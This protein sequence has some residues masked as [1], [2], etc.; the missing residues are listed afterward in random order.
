MHMG[1]RF[2]HHHFIHLHAT[3]D[4]Q[5]SQVIAFQIDEHDMFRTLLGVLNKLLLDRR[6]LLPRLHARSCA[7]DGTGFNLLALDADQTLRRG[8]DDRTI[9]KCSKPGKR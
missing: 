5:A 4:T 6:I 3:R 7:G 1:V 8:A 2:N 9:G